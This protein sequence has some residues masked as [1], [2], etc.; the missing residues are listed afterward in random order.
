MQPENTCAR[1]LDEL[2]ARG[3]PSAA[4]AAHLA[5][6][7]ECRGLADTIHGLRRL[8][9]AYPEGAFPALKAKV[10]A[11][12]IPAAATASGGAGAAAAASS[13]LLKTA[14]AI[15]VPLAMVTGLAVVSLRQPAAP[16]AG[17]APTQVAAP[18]A[19]HAPLATPAMAVATPAAAAH[20]AAPLA[21]TLLPTDKE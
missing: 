17:S 10:L 6:C 7:P 20:Q 12:S 8:P 1:F 19:S 9:S 16:G 11:S 15:L 13:S 21:D 4:L 14:A 2:L 5:T 18:A 3:Q